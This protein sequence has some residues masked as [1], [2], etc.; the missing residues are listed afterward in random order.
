[1]TSLSYWRA[2]AALLVS[3]T[4][5][6]AACSPALNWRVVQ[7]ADGLELMLPCKPS[8]RKE[9]VRLGANDSE[10]KMI[11]CQA[12]GM[13]FTHSQLSLPPQVTPNE[14]MARWQQASLMPLGP[15]QAQPPRPQTLTGVVTPA[16]SLRV[17]TTRGMQVQF[18]WWHQGS[19]VHQLAVYGPTGEKTFEAAV[20]AFMSSIKQRP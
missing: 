6:L 14:L 13:D 10:L 8:E 16:T 18:V 7:P 19:L 11:G 2:T 9:V 20:D 17:T 5:L 1:M 3:C 4:G 12:Q 15:H